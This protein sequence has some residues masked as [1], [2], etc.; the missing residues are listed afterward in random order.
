MINTGYNL[1]MLGREFN[2][3]SRNIFLMRRVLS[4]ECVRLMAR[5]GVERF[6][7]GSAVLSESVEKV[8]V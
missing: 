6:V 5:R 1:G 7:C 3:V 4:R 2:L 8:S